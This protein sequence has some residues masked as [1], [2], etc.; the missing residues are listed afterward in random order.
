VKA[1]A[2]TNLVRPLG[3]EDLEDPVGGLFTDNVGHCKRGIEK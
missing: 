2:K 1:T 3:F